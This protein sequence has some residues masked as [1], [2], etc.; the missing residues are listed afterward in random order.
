MRR[1]LP[2]N[3]KAIKKY[4]IAK[5]I[6]VIELSKKMGLSR[7]SVYNYELG[8]QMPTPKQLVKIAKFLET[9]P[10]QLMEQQ[11]TQKTERTKRHST[12]TAEVP[13]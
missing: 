3:A 6:T 4:R 9:E 1:V 8:I 2:V 7:T 5:G 10:I 11:K 13:L 12:Y